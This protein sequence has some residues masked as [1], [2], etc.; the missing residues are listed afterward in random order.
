MSAATGDVR[1]TDFLFQR[2]SV[3]IQ[4][5]DSVLI[6]ESFGVLDLEPDL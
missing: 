4:R 3:V 6:H 1:E 5:Y 2:L